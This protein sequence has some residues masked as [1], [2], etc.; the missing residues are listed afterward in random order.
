MVNV[1]FLNVLA[2]L[3]L[4]SPARVKMTVKAMHPDLRTTQ[5][6]RLLASAVDPGEARR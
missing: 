6:E 1:I 5:Q 4:T 3:W 2:P